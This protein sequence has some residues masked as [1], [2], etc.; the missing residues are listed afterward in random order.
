MRHRSHL[1]WH[2]RACRGI[3]FA[4]LRWLPKPR[5]YVTYVHRYSGYGYHGGYDHC[6]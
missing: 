2:F 4:N 6:D 5:A 3:G 1:P